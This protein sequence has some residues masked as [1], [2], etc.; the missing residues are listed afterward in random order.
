MRHR[1]A[2]RAYQLGGRDIAAVQ[3]LLGHAYVTTTQVYVEVDDNSVRR[4]ALAAAA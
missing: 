2:T 4:A 3:R 1:Y